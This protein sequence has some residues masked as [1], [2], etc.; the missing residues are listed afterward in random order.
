[1]AGW[2]YGF[3]T[4]SMP[5]VIKI[6]ATRREPDERLDEANASDTWRPPHPYAVTCTAQVD[7][8]FA[9][10]RAIHT[11]LAARRVSP[12]HEFFELTALE[13]RTLF[14]LLAPQAEQ[15]EQSEENE[16]PEQAEQAEQA[17]QPRPRAWSA[18][19]RL[20]AWVEARYTHVPL[21]E[22]DSGTKLEAL[23]TAYAS[24]VPPVHT[25]PLGK[26]LFAKMLNVVYPN[27]GPHRNG[28]NTVSGLY[29]LR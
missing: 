10:E 16:Q 9:C 28:P 1:M 7:D 13:A 20:R 26:I 21:R 11:L 25:R 6:G 4:P 19:S 12:R 8:P 22:K 27:I 14:S 24:A 5:G 2:V 18:E 3:A 17:E 23:Y 15:G 29:L